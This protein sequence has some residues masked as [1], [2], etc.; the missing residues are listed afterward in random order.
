MRAGYGEPQAQSLP[1][2]PLLA[3]CTRPPPDET[4]D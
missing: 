3:R 2:A 1:G 4:R